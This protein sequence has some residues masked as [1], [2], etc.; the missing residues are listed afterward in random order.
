M[1]G[2]DYY[3]LTS[4]RNGCN[5]SYD[6]ISMIAKDVERYYHFSTPEF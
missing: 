6:K 1:K 2:N 3:L 5:V 4:G